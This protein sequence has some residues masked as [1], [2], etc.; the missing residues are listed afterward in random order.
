MEAI[1]ADPNVKSMSLYSPKGTSF[2]TFA[3]DSV[4][5]DNSTATLPSNLNSALDDGNVIRFYSKVES[6]HTHCCQ[7]DIKGTSS[8]G[9]YY[10]VLKSSVSKAELIAVQARMRMIFIL[11]AIGNL[12]LAFIMAR[13]VSRRLVKNIRETVHRVRSIK[14]SGSITERIGI[15]GEDEV[16]FPTKEFD[17]LLDQREKSQH[18]VVEAE[19]TASKVQLAKVVAHN[20][21]SPLLAIEMMIPQ[22]FMLPERTRR[23]LANS[24]NEIKDLS[25]QLESK[26][27]S[28]VAQDSSASQVGEYVFMPIL[29]EDVV[30]QKQIEYSKRSDV[31]IK[32]ENRVNSADVFVKVSS[33]ELRSTL[34]NLINNAIESYGGALAEVTIVH[35][36][37]DRVC[38]ISIQDKGCGIPEEMRVKLGKDQFSSKPGGKRGF[39]IAHAIKTVEAWGGQIRFNAA[40]GP[41]TE[42]IVEIPRQERPKLLRRI[43]ETVARQ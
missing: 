9:E 36:A 1:K 14:E 42:V 17:K 13:L 24:V 39:G 37:T 18:I 21:R 29:V 31:R 41:G 25:E 34:S 5:F 15:Q 28:L 27:E 4:E 40:A 23:V 3:A 11:L 8:S 19:K 6:S 33:T 35:S 10:Y 2:G 22:M 20:I 16:A 26:P 30:N 12:G 38:S 43:M 7:C 32:F